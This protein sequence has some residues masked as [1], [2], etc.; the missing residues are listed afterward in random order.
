MAKNAGDLKETGNAEETEATV[1]ASSDG[2]DDDKVDNGHRREKVADKTPFRRVFIAVVGGNELENVVDDEDKSAE[3]VDEVERPETFIVKN[4]GDEADQGNDN[5]E[6]IIIM[7]GGVVLREGLDD[8]KNFATPVI[9][10]AGLA[11][12]G[13]RARRL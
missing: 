11:P 5:H 10:K 2:K 9:G 1:D 6:T 4:E 13:G 3:D 7:R 8:V 12:V